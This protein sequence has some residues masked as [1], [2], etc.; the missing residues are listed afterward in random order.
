MKSPRVSVSLNPSDV[1]V[2]H[3]ICKKKQMTMSALT[4]KMVED[5][6]EDYEDLLLSRRAEEAE[7]RWIE[8]GCKTISHEEV[9]KS[10]GL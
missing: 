4:K 1:E 9:W 5:W 10:L 3:L 7:K 6:L 8:D 2:M